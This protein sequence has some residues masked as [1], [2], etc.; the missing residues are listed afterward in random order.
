MGYIRKFQINQKSIYYQP[1]PYI[2]I[3]SSHISFYQKDNRDTGTMGKLK[4]PRFIVNSYESLY[5]H[6]HT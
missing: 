4:G 1:E 6:T 3:F 2:K 5:T